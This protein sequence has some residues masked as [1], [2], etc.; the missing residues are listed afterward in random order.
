MAKIKKILANNIKRKRRKCGFTQAQLAEKVN[1]STH[2]IAMIETARD[3][4]TMEL[5]ERIAGVLDIEIYELFLEQPEPKDAMEQLHDS[6]VENIQS[7]IDNA[8]KKA[9]AEQYIIDKP[10]K[11][12]KKQ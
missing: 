8:V 6:I 5:A 9:V 2:H 12:P 3:N 10:K 1:V 7:V 4:P 11:K